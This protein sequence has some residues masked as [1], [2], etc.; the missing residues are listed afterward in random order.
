[1][2]HAKTV[3]PALGVALLLTMAAACG[4]GKPGVGQLS[5]GA[6]KL[7]LQG[8]SLGRLVDVYAYQRIDLSNANPTNADRRNRFN[9]R[10]ELVA[11]NVVVNAN[12]EHSRC[13]TRR[14]RSGRQRTTSS[15]RS[16]S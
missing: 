5:G 14:A 3:T 4:G 15:G 11:A 9:R 12:L 7:T 1:M 6:A 10:L 8:V 13:S 2:K 16:T